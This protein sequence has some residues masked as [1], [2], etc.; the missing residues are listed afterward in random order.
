MNIK[1]NHNNKN[2]VT[3]IFVISATS[4]HVKLF[5][6]VFELNRVAVA[7]IKPKLG[8]TRKLKIPMFTK[9]LILH[10]EMLQL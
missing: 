6:V 9:T 1:I 2:Y 4:K 3:K 10:P 7:R 5:E 8:R